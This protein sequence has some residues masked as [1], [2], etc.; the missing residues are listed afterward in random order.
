MRDKLKWQFMMYDRD[1]SGS[2][3]TEEM[4][5]MFVMMCQEPEHQDLEPIELKLAVKGIERMAEEMFCDLDA[6]GDGF[7]TQVL[8]FGQDRQ[9]NF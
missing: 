2:I 7:V 6:D 8:G 9:R 5:G 3:T 1:G 4:K